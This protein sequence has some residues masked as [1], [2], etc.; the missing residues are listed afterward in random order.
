M[1][2]FELG[3]PL[4]TIIMMS[5]KFR[6]DISN[7]SEVI[8]LTDRQSQPQTGTAEKNTTLAVLHNV[9]GNNWQ[10]VVWYDLSVDETTNCE[11]TLILFLCSKGGVLTC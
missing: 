2:I 11:N 9:G 3:T 1:A 5:W 4:L 8:V 6:D 7:G 10:F